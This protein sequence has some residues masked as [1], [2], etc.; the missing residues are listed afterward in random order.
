M[1]QAAEDAGQTLAVDYNYRH[2][3]SFARVADA[4]EKGELGTVHLVSVD[5][6]AYGWHHVLDLLVFFLGEPESVRATLDHDPTA[7]AEQYRLD[8]VLYVPSHAIT[9]TIDF[10]DRTFATVSASI[11]AS[12][13]D[14][15]IDL[16][17]YADA[18]RVRLAGITPGDSTGTVVFGPLSDDLRGVESITLDESFDRSIDAFVDAIQTGHRP[19]TTGTDGLRRLELERAVVESAESG[20]WVEL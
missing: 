16:A 9:A 12:L 8:E 13:D 7:V 2:M 17:V 5:A 18:G 14:H 19:P 20:E 1:V 3:P 4:I 11:H 10:G 15:L 6:H